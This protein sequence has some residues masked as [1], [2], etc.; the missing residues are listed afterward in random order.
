M[1]C[2]VMFKRNFFWTRM[3]INYILENSQIALCNKIVKLEI[4]SKLRSYFFY[5]FNIILF[6]RYL[7]SSSLYLV[8]ILINESKGKARVQIIEKMKTSYK[9]FYLY[10][11]Y[12]WTF[13]LCLLGF[14]PIHVRLLLFLEIWSLIVLFVLMAHH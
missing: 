6:I 7:V 13:S 4:S 9:S 14:C 5:F 10:P 11:I 1:F 2:C 12:F 3:I 8:G